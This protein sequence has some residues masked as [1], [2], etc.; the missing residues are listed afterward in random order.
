MSD[1]EL[2]ALKQRAAEVL[3]ARPDVT[4]VGLG[5]RD[6]GGLPTG[7][8]VLKVFVERK[9][10]LTGLT[11]GETLPPRFEGLG[12]DVG[13][14]PLAEATLTT[15]PVLDDTLT[16]PGSPFRPDS[17][18]DDE[19][20]RTLSGGIRVQSGLP[21]AG[22]GTMGCLLE[23]TTDPGKV[24]GLT[25]F[26]VL[27]KVA[28]G[29]ATPV[30]DSTRLGHPHATTSPLKCCSNMF[31]TFA[32]GG[33]DAV[34]D[35]ALIQ[36]DPGTKWLPEIV[37]LGPLGG[38]RPASIAEIA[39]GTLRVRK[40]GAHTTLTGGVLNVAHMTITVE[41][42]TRNN[43]MVAT[44]NPNPLL[45]AG[46]DLFFSQ[47]GDS[48]SVLVD[49]DAVVVALHYA[50]LK[51]P[52]NIHIGF[53]LPI[54]DILASFGGNE[55]LPLRVATATTNG[56]VHVVPGTRPLDAPRDLLPSPDGTLPPLE[57]VLARVGSDLERSAAGRDLIDLWLDHH[58]ELLRLVDE[59]RRVTIAW[60]RGG[61]PVLMHAL[62]HAVADPAV[63]MPQA[64]NGE[65]TARRL[66]R[67]LTAFH[68]A[69]SPELR[70]ALDRT[71]E[72]LPD[73]AGLT[74]PQLLTALA[75]G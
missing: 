28:D 56:D 33:S 46:E 62:L 1:E 4:A 17:A 25:N 27:S 50:G 65:S 41:G 51:L 23:H 68:A 69:A 19:K 36:L 34:R 29:T 14:L 8:I 39:A 54:E 11:P 10:P 16:V 26:H 59:R 6:R 31:G 53:E 38:S 55:Q 58:D 52:G 45:G 37:G 7:E 43:V 3:M 48:G 24:Y 49:D 57:D 5:G 15:T 63:T 9:R 42:A 64:V 13:E 60:H 44:P 61:G 40:R 21:G 20:R 22:F 75:A 72:A 35:A 47:G 66:D 32:G 2:V 12:V 70:R 67:I 74:Y 71:R 30:K 73:P 18:M